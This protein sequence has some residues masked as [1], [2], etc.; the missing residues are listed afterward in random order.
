[1]NDFRNDSFIFVLSGIIASMVTILCFIFIFK[2]WREGKRIGLTSEVMRRAIFSSGIF[3]IIPSFSILLAVLT[4]SGALG[5]AVPWGKLNF[6]GAIT[7]DLTMA[8]TVAQAFKSSTKAP[9]MDKTVFVSVAW[10]MTLGTIFALLVVTFFAKR[11]QIGIHKAQDR[12]KTW[13]NL[14]ISAMF[15]G[16][17]SVFLGNALGSGTVSILTLLSSA[18][19]MA[20]FGFL[21]KKVN[22]KWLESYALPFSMVAGMGAAVLFT[23]L[24]KGGFAS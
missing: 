1:M 12:D 22:V 4:L 5:L 10:A 19:F 23:R 21:I 15:M 8:E 24:L 20:G 2:A 18:V 6:N 14:L 9:I 3:S 17:I 16:L 13:V 11:I 7:Y